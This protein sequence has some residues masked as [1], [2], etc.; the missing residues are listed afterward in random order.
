MLTTLDGVT[1]FEHLQFK[2]QGHSLYCIH[3]PEDAPGNWAE[4]LSTDTITT[5]GR[6]STSY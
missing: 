6:T 2:Y 5:T 4:W 3:A 1:V